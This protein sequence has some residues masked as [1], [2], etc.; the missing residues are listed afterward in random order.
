M[1]QINLN[2][3]ELSCQEGH[4]LVKPIFPETQEVSESGIVI[5]M[6]KPMIDARPCCGEVVNSGSTDFNSGDFVV[7]PT[8][9]GID[10]QLNDGQFL[11]LKETSV[12]AKRK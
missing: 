12:I 10:C 6:R 2:S 9:D 11:F 5:Q 1:Q 3:T 7:F 4:L 8:T